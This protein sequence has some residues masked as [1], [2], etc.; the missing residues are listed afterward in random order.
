[1]SNSRSSKLSLVRTTHGDLAYIGYPPLGEDHLLRNYGDLTRWRRGFEMKTRAFDHLHKSMIEHK[2]MNSFAEYDAEAKA[3][4][5]RRWTTLTMKNHAG[6]RDSHIHDGTGRSSHLEGLPKDIKAWQLMVQGLNDY[7]GA[8]IMAQC[9]PDIQNT[10]RNKNLEL[11]GQGALDYLR[12][13]STPID[14]HTEVLAA[15]ARVKSISQQ[16]NESFTSY[17]TKYSELLTAYTDLAAR[18]PNVQ[19][20]SPSLLVNLMVEN[21]YDRGHVIAA[22]NFVDKCKSEHDNAMPNA[23]TVLEFMTSRSMKGLLTDLGPK[24]NVRAQASHARGCRSPVRS[25]RRDRDDDKDDRG[26]RSR[27]RPSRARQAHVTSR[28]GTAHT[29]TLNRGGGRANNSRTNNSRNHDSPGQFNRSRSRSTG[30]N[31]RSRSSPPSMPRRNILRTNNRAGSGGRAFG[32]T[33]PRALVPPDRLLR[34]SAIRRSQAKEDRKRVPFVMMEGLTRA[35]CPIPSDMRFQKYPS[36][37]AKM[38]DDRHDNF[39]PVWDLPGHH[40]W[41]TYFTNEHPDLKLRPLA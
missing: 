13:L 3:G 2:V 36:D 20:D 25:H 21:L 26:A 28:S 39:V 14:S 37:L 5:L 30:R 7:L 4:N 9:A 41:K 10:L 33:L 29:V 38:L 17:Q 23:S 8:L 12:S 24:H 18:S 32:N 22:R 15:Q 27:S 34:E 11:D 19:F 35:E 1:M 31:D 6:L 16:P 40:D